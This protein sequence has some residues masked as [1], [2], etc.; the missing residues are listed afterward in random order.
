MDWTFP[1]DAGEAGIFEMGRRLAERIGHLPD[2]TRFTYDAR[3]MLRIT[4]E[5]E[6]VSR[7]GNLWVG[8]QSAA[9]LELEHARYV[10]LL[11][12][13]SH[14][15]AY[16]AGR[17]GDL[18][19]ALDFR[20]VAPDHRR[21]ENQWFLVSDRPDTVAFVS[22]ELGDPRLFG[23]GGAATPGKRFVG[24]VTDDPA[25]VAELITILEAVKGVPPQSPPGPPPAPLPGTPAG[26]LLAAVE[27]M[28]ASP[29]GA[30]EGAV[31]VPIGRGDDRAALVLALAIAR[32]EA[33]PLV[34][35]D[36]SGEGLFS[37]PYSDLRGDDEL[38]PQPDRLFGALVARREG[39]HA[40]TTALEVADALGIKAGGWFPTATGADGLGEA[41]RRFHGSLLVLPSAVRH[42]GFAE[43]LRGMS[44]DRLGGLDATLVVAD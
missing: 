44:L 41:L 22:W 38:R 24:F 28:L 43:R 29:S 17:P 30:L 19:D 7:G 3:D 36:R 10:D 37:S 9:K 15:R 8:F 11:A 21:L 39:R 12:A 4:R 33:R 40:T 35:V 25:V 27:G 31:I 23:V 13:G 20:E 18:P 1:T 34:F 42:P 2:A 32:S 6:A 16:A 14:I 26:D 5:I